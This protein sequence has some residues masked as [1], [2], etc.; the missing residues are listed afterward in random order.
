MHRRHL[1][2][3]EIDTIEDALKNA[4]SLFEKAMD[5]IRLI[6]TKTITKKDIHNNSKNRAIMLPIWDEIKK[7]YSIEAFM[8]NSHPVERIKRKIVLYSDEQLMED[9]KTLFRKAL[10]HRLPIR[11]KLL[12]RYLDETIEELTM[13]KKK[14]TKKAYTDIEIEDTKG[15]KEHFRLLDDGLLIRPFN[16]ITVTKMRDDEL[17]RYIDDLKISSWSDELTNK[18]YSLAYEE[19]SKRGLVFEMPF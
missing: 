10:I 16:T 8:H 18:K 14:E 4:V 17:L 11:A 7:N 15:N 1:K 19:A 12:E 2:E 5:D 13:P 6:D 9:C 3:Y